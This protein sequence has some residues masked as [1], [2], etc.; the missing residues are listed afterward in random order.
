M[1]C[2]SPPLQPSLLR[3]IAKRE[4]K[5]MPLELVTIPC[6]SDNYAFLLHDSDSG[7]TALIDAPDAAPILKELKERGWHLTDVWLT[8]HH[9]DHVDGLPDLQKTIP[10]LRVWG[11]ADD[12]HRLPKLD[13]ALR[14]GDLP[15]FAGHE[16]K[17]FDVSGHTLG[18][19]AF[20]V[21]GAG[22][23]FTAD[24]LIAMG[25]GRLFEGTPDMMWRNLSKLAALPDETLI[26]SGHEYTA[27]NM[28]FALSLEPENPALRLRDASITTARDA[29]LPTVPSTLGLERATNPFLRASDPVL[30]SALG[31]A[32][33]D[34][35]TVFAETRARKDKF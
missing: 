12:A 1:H 31:M 15:V 7:A 28:R 35:A 21:P 5:T 24:S 30:K 20:Y 23:A 9:W 32:D 8:H 6:L 11:S 13:L 2:E 22:L 10:G 26:C 19:I 33:A 18:H 17:V 16:V 34:D 29:G 27:A 3:S 25:C 4:Q 14:E